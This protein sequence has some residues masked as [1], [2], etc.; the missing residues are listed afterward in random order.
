MR[1]LPISL[2]TDNNYIALIGNGEAALNKLRLLVKTHA[3]IKLYAPAPSIAL[4]Q[5]LQSHS[6]IAIIHL[7]HQFT[8]LDLP[9]LIAIFSCADNHH[10]NIS[11]AKLAKSINLPFNSPDN[12]EI[13]TFNIPSIVDRSPVTIAISTEGT[14]PVLAKKIRATIEQQLSPNIGKLAI[15]AQNFR[16]IVKRKLT[17]MTDKRHFWENF[18]N[19]KIAEKF[20]SGDLAQTNQLANDA[21]SNP[22]APNGK[23][24]IIHV[25]DPDLLSIKSARIMQLADEIYQIES[26]NID[27]E[28]F[29]NFARRD[30]Q[31]TKILSNPDKPQNGEL[32][33]KIAKQARDGKIIVL[34]GDNSAKARKNNIFSHLQNEN[35]EIEH[36]YSAK[37]SDNY[38][39]SIDEFRKQYL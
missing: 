30:A 9:N 36:L 17:T 13:C 4:I 6:N 14:A 21:L 35:I 25:T 15:Y 2:K 12:P 22:Q 10:E 8:K 19:G 20:L 23:F 11:V 18:F 38:A 24:Y 37:P 7:H 27:I 34:L 16:H 29:A 31:Y 26:N 1:Y 32:I 28:T 3:K 5:Y 33:M 39:Q